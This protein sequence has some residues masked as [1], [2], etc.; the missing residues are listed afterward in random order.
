MNLVTEIGT[1]H[2]SLSRQPDS[3]Y[4]VN[5]WYIPGG[6]DYVNASVIVGFWPE[7]LK[8]EAESFH[9]KYSGPGEMAV[10]TDLQD[11]NSKEA[12]K[13]QQCK[14]CKKEVNYNFAYKRWVS[15]EP[16]LLQN[17]CWMDPIKGSQVHEV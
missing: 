8:A 17:Y 3:R 10:L 1:L 13:P 4:A 16:A 2:G 15:N 7:E 9:N 5:L 14:H 12:Y 11:P 6:Y